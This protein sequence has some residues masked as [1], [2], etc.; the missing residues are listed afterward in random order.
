MMKLRIDEHTLPRYQTFGMVALVL[1]LLIGIVGYFLAQNHFSNQASLQDLRDQIIQQQLDRTQNELDATLDYIRFKKEQSEVQLRKESKAQVDQALVLAQSIYRQEQ[2]RL[3][4][5]EI[6]TLL[7]EAF[8][9][10]RFF[11]DRGYLFVID[12][13]GNSVLND[14]SPHLEGRSTLDLQDDKGV[15]I[16]QKIINVVNGSASHSGYVRYRWYQPG[17]DRM[18]DKLSYARLFEPLGWIIATGDYLHEAE[19][20]IKAATLKRIENLRFGDNGYIAVI[21]GDGEV[22]SSPGWSISQYADTPEVARKLTSEAIDAIVQSG[23]SGGGIVRYF[24]YYPDGRGPVQKISRVIAVPEW[25]WYL[26]SGV[27]PEDVDQLMTEQ[28]HQLEGSQSEDTSALISALVIAAVLSLLLALWF[29]KGMER[30]FKIYQA[31]ISHKQQKLENNAKRLQVAASVFQNSSEGIMVADSNNCLVAVNDAF[32]EITGF[33]RE[34]ALGRNP[35][36]L[37]SGRHDPSFYEAMWGSLRDEGCWRGEIWN[38]RKDGALYPQWLSISASRDNDGQVDNYIATFLD[39]SERKEAEH[40]LRYMSEYDSLTDLPNRHLLNQRVSRALDLAGRSSGKQVALLLVDLDR[41]KNINDSL[42]HTTGDRVL[43][44][45]ARRLVTMVHAEDTVCRMGGDEFAILMTDPLLPAA[46]VTLAERVLK[47]VSDPVLISGRQLV[48]TSSIG[49]SVYPADGTDF[50]T[51]IRNADT[52]LYHAKDNGRNGFQFYTEGM[53]QQVSQRLDMEHGLRQA[54]EEQ[55]FQLHYQPQYDLS[56]DS[57]YGCEALIRWY[58]DDGG[59]QRPDH[60]IPIAEETGLI[61]PIGR[62]VLVEACEQGAKWLQQGLPAINIAVNLS[63]IQFGDQLVDTVREVLEQTQFPPSKL[64]LEITES[65]LMRNADRATELLDELKQ[66]GVGLAL[67]DFGTGYS[68][69]AYLKKFPLDKLKI[70]R[71][72]ISGLPDDLDDGAITSSIIDIA[73]NL[74]LQ[75]VAEGIE[76]AAQ[77]DHL[78][79]EGCD[80]VQGYFYARP[81]P[82]NDFEAL[83]QEIAS[84]LL[85]IK[86]ADAE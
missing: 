9:G 68:S 11:D 48:M 22:I 61:V 32:T 54:I 57:L 21:R 19:N 62:W 28:R 45:I 1:I 46:A 85:N 74:G 47:I 52:A 41:F 17:S 83:Q 6:K 70:D 33:S 51:L 37:K 31:D 65:I 3:S 58:K 50:D 34:D 64:T 25:N 8:R 53:N 59:Y 43:Q 40:K 71:A 35:S 14:H 84:G 7:R 26:V 18:F 12:T 73:R 79:A 29:S 66:L 5:Y 80:L 38:R 55:Q 15:F 20:D 49:I 4:D 27:Y 76:T 77:R 10:V 81:M 42:G 69:L 16:D 56:D 23:K 75:T 2:G 44:Q 82:A 72:F 78:I 13:E 24:W 36:L 67:D 60:F 63:A 86:T 39:M 30:L